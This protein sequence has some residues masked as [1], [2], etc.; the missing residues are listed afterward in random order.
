MDSHQLPSN[1]PLQYHKHRFP[2]PVLPYTRVYRTCIIGISLFLLLSLI[3]NELWALFAS[4]GE[5]CQRF[6][7]ANKEKGRHLEPNHIH[8]PQQPSIL[9]NN[10]NISEQIGPNQ[11]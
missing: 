4:Q 5:N 9:A 3:A 6:S 7:S 10:N 11:P 1:A 8:E 2:P